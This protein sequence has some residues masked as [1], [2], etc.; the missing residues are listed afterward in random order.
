MKLVI[1]VLVVGCFLGC[2][3]G[4]RDSTAPQLTEYDALFLAVKLANEECS[5]QFSVKPFDESS[6]SVSFKNG[7]WHWGELDLSGV[8]G[9]SGVV[10][11][12]P[13]GKHPSVE[14]FL[15]TDL[16][17]SVPPSN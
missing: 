10:T 15:S 6:F 16:P 14:V 9:F 7:K 4:F 11:F 5:K 1:S 13:W 3:S 2:Q 12:D 17:R 8:N